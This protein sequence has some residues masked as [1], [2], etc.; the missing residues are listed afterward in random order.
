MDRHLNRSGF[1]FA[2]DNR[3]EIG[4]LTVGLEICADHGQGVLADRPEPHVH[5]QLIVSGGMSIARGPVTVPA[6]GP[7]FLVDGFGRTEVSSN[8]FGQGMRY[9][10]ADTGDDIYNTGPV[11]WAGL[12]TSLREWLA[13]VVDDLTGLWGAA[14]AGFQAADSSSVLRLNALGPLWRQHIQ[15]LFVSAPYDMVTAVYALLYKE[16][17]PTYVKQAH[18]RRMKGLIPARPPPPP[19]TFPTVDCYPPMRIMEIPGHK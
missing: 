15:G 17:E 9:A 8:L 16:L 19:P 1:R 18:R 10:R 6:G 11:R 7:V 12:Y 3:F 14:P 2:R 5:L 13:L 4:G